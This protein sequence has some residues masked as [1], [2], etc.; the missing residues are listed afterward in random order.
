MTDFIPDTDDWDD[1]TE[2]GPDNWTQIP[3][4]NLFN[5]AHA[6]IVPTYV[7]SGDVTG[8]L[9]DGKK[10]AVNVV[11]DVTLG[12]PQISILLGDGETQVIS[13]SGAYSLPVTADFSSRSEIRIKDDTIVGVGNALLEFVSVVRRGN[14]IISANITTTVV[15]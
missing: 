6:A 4:A 15:R 1:V 13:T 14:R 5:L 7:V 12:A 3:G 11:L 8:D 10:Y 9:T 2:D